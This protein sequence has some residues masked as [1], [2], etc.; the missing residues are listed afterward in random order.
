MSEFTKTPSRSTL[1]QAFFLCLVL[2]VASLWLCY[3]AIQ[4][5]KFVFFDN[6]SFVTTTSG[7]LIFFSVFVFSLRAVY[8]CIKKL[9]T[10]DKSIKIGGEK[11]VTYF[12]GFALL[13]TPLVVRPSMHSYLKSQS[14]ERCW[15]APGSTGL[16]SRLSPKWAKPSVGC[17]VWDLPDEERKAIRENKS[18]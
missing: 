15:D 13:A 6:L 10:K 17:E 12:M 7:Y 16:T 5:L 2:F 8:F 4:E 1:L 18:N 9:T 11:F 14:Y 3:S